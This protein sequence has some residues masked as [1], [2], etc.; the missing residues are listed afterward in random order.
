MNSKSFFNKPILSLICM[1][2][3]SHTTPFSHAGSLP[4]IITSKTRILAM[5][6]M[7]M[8]GQSQLALQAS[9]TAKTNATILLW[10]SPSSWSGGVLPKVGDEVIIPDGA[11]ILLDQN[12]NV[13][14][15]SVMGS[16]IMD[17]TKDLNIS[18]EYIMVMGA[19][20]LFEC[21]TEANPYLKKVVIT[22]VG[23]DA[24][25][26]ISG[27][28]VSS[29]A[30]MVMTGGK[31]ELHG[32]QKT[33]WLKINKTANIGDNTITLSAAVPS[34]EK[35]DSIVI[36]STDKN[37]RNAEVRAI[38]N[39]VGT[40]VTLDKPLLY[41]HFGEILTFNQTTKTFDQRA[42]VGLLT[43]NIKIQS[44]FVA[45][46]PSGFGGHIMVMLG[47][48]AHVEN[49]ELHRMGQFNQ[50]G[51]YPFHWHIC[52]DV[53]G[54]YFK[55]STIKYSNNRAL[56][57]H[58]TDNA[59]IEGNVAYRHI[60]HGFFLEDGD[61]EGNTFKNNLGL[62]TIAPPVGKELDAGDDNPATFWITNPN[63][64]F[65]GNVAAG[66]ASTGFWIIPLRNLLRDGDP[67]SKGGVPRDY[68]LKE[69]VNNTG[70]SNSKRN[71]ALD[72]DVVLKAGKRTLNELEPR[73]YPI[74][75]ING[76][77]MR[78]VLENFVSYKGGA[79][80]A[81][82]RVGLDHRF[83]NA[84]FGDAGQMAF[85]AFNAHIEN[86]MFVAASKNTGPGANYDYGDILGLQMYNGSCDAINV[87]LAGFIDKSKVCIGNRRSSG[88]YPNFTATGITFENDGTEDNKVNLGFFTSV[89]DP[90]R[91]Y[92]FAAG[93][94][95]I[96]GSISGQAGIRLTPMIRNTFSEKNAQKANS[97]NYLKNKIFDAN[98]NQPKQL[99]KRVALPVTWNA[100]GSKNTEFAL[101]MNFFSF[102]PDDD[103]GEN[104][105]A[106]YGIRSDGPVVYDELHS[107][108][109]S[110]WPVIVNEDYVYNYQ[111]HRLP[112]D[113]KS[114]FKWS[115]T[116]NSTVMVKYLNVPSN[117]KIEKK[118]SSGVLQLT[119]VADL[120]A[121]NK[122]MVTAYYLKNNTLHIKYVATSGDQGLNT[123]IRYKDYSS[124]ELEINF[125]PTNI[126]SVAGGLN[127][128]TLADY[129]VGVD[130][131][132]TIKT[133]GAITKSAIT[134][135]GTVS[136]DV[137]DHKN[138]FS[139]SKSTSSTLGYAEYYLKTSRQVWR[140]F[141]TLSLN[142]TGPNVEVLVVDSLQG[143]Y[144]LGSF[145]A[146]DSR[147]IDMSVLPDNYGDEVLGIKL[148]FNDCFLTTTA[149]T[150]DLFGITLS[151]IPS[152]PASKTTVSCVVT[153]LSEELEKEQVKIYPN[154]SIDGV[155]NLS[156][157]SNWKV[158]TLAGKELKAGKGTIIQLSEYPKGVYLIKMNEKVERIVIE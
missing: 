103:E 16:L 50:V 104:L 37:Y 53:T 76:D 117:I 93:M 81:W 135:N 152:T 129:E 23:N 111:L 20:A 58:G 85:L 102:T 106:V 51:R 25:A 97:A 31:L 63:N 107:S 1:F 14:S 38:T 156:Q 113:F 9:I 87:H 136:T 155:F 133:V 148:R 34:W 120:D 79:N 121:L 86:S 126:A 158:Y 59:L 138:S 119:S 13:K 154:P 128:V 18:T 145:K 62:S 65:I 137:I 15:I 29:K 78:Y 67:L 72:G 134:G 68:P 146:S 28:G 101:F 36:A 116:R 27:H 109:N 147:N 143:D 74:I 2:A 80:G 66:G 131:R 98:F 90:A 24:T 52:G 149:Q 12:V 43:R 125:N 54:Q 17:R 33:S 64:T 10:S 100:V 56:T 21:G 47:S 124:D 73:G 55:N 84:R 26:M 39:V 32:Q 60:G 141:N 49:V 88:K 110:Q 139:I 8:A 132:A 22:L 57:V 108:R 142:Y 122:S 153:S 71:L 112:N 115:K 42:E 151:L 11:K 83:I 94:I 91:S 96:D 123:S 77:T 150:V 75:D 61:E 35:G 82:T 157:L 45:T 5:P 44:E 118:L 69:F 92:C 19:N 6:K 30:I 130:D 105:N 99:S 144:S 48:Q 114:E 70:H 46:T 89:E 3:I 41:K 140:E 127:Y 95:D 7:C 40:L 4:Q